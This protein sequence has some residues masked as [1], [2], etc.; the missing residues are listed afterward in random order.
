MKRTIGF[1]LLEL[2]VTM[3][4]VGILAAVAI[5]RLTDAESKA[6]W[7]HEQVKAG[8]RYAQRQAVAQR[9]CV[10]VAASATQVSLFYGDTSCAITTAPV[11]QLATGGAYVLVAPSGVAIVPATFSFNG[12]GQ[13]TPPVTLNVGGKT[14][15][16]I[17][18]TGHVR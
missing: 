9:R 2:V 6:T 12:L 18:E 4:I 8:V 1:S 14:V 7:F 16:V 13:P 15:E 3:V 11:T 5:P 17:A 10:F